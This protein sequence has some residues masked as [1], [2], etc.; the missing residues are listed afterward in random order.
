M[1]T[2]ADRQQGRLSEQGVRV[3]QE[4]T[5][6]R[7]T[8][9]Y[10]VMEYCRGQAVS[11]PANLHDRQPGQAFSAHHEPDP[12]FPFVSNHP[13]LRKCSIAQ[14]ANEC[15]DRIGWKIDIAGEV[16]CT[17]QNSSSC[18]QHTRQ[19]WKDTPAFCR[20]ECIEDAV[21]VRTR[22]P[23]HTDDFPSSP[24]RTWSLLHIPHVT[25]GAKST[26]LALGC[27]IDHR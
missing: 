1:V 18:Q 25:R 20:S 5:A 23:V 15:E 27:A 12:T 8:P 6:Y 4:Q 11:E 9:P 17:T 19:T 13:D 26:A 21:V 3:P 22:R 14:H 7:A 16:A 10:F 2:S 24:H